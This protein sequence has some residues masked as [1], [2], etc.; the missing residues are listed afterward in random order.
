MH[1]NTLVLVSLSH[2]SIREEE[3][4]IFVLNTSHLVESPQV[5]MEAVIVVTS[6]EFDFKAAVAAHVG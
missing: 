2:L 6:T 4:H 3:H 1:P 5:L